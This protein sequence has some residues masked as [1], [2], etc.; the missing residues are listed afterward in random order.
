LSVFFGLIALAVPAWPK[1]F[2]AEGARG[3]LTTE[4]K[5]PKGE[6]LVGITGRSGS[7][8]DQLQIIC[9]PYQSDGKMGNAHPVEPSVGGKGGGPAGGNEGP[10]RAPVGAAWFGLTRDNRQI[11]VL[12]LVCMR[13]TWDNTAFFSEGPGSQLIGN[14]K[15]EL[16]DDTGARFEQTCPDGEAASGFNVN[17]G[18]HVN[19]IGL[20]CKALVR[21]AAPRDPVA[22]KAANDA[23]LEERRMTGKTPQ[24]CETSRQMCTARVERMIPFP[25][26]QAQIVQ[27][28][29]PFFNQCMANAQADLA[30]AQPKVDLTSFTGVWDTKTSAGES[31][32]LILEFQS[33]LPSGLQGVSG[34]FGGADASLSGTLSGPIDEGRRKFGFSFEQPKA[35]RSG[36]GIFTL[37]DDGK[38]ISG[39]FVPDQNTT[40]RI[41]WTGT[42]RD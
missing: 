17:H 15:T 24:Q 10:C 13:S 40:Q 36:N 31:Y 20:R 19:A 22:D 29:I 1:Q 3:D 4:L 27:Q 9:A 25:H 6:Y 37:G 23:I 32:T 7:W 21:A 33:N 18:R 41:Q 16:A 8:I 39:Y 35:D 38:T 34:Y 5:C 30:A 11:K 2:P 42:R 26:S 12:T 14:D 28:C